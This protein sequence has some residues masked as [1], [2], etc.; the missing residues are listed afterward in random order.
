MCETCVCRLSSPFPS[1]FLP[2]SVDVVFLLTPY[3]GA[4]SEAADNA[5][6]AA[7]RTNTENLILLLPA[8][9]FKQKLLWR[10]LGVGKQ[11]AYVMLFMLIKIR[12]VNI[13][14]VAVRSSSSKKIPSSK[15]RIFQICYNLPI[16]D[17]LPSPTESRMREK[18][19]YRAF[20]V[21]PKREKKGGGGRCPNSPQSIRAVWGEKES[22]IL[23]PSSG[24]F[25]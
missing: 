25:V 21:C 22:Y 5:A 17:R 9:R 23:F 3:L 13:F 6:A 12:Q 24:L 8:S 7:K 2:P 1:L 18:Y 10:N 15:K 4:Y 19:G 20:C 14:Q 16:A 11:R